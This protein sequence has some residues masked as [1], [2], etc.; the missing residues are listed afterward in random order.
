MRTTHCYLMVKHTLTHLYTYAFC[1]TRTVLGCFLLL[2]NILVRFLLC[3]SS[4]FIFV[5]YVVQNVQMSMHGHGNISMDIDMY[6]SLTI[7]TIYGSA[8]DELRDNKENEWEHYW[9]LFS[10]D[11][12]SSA[13]KWQE[14]RQ[15]V[16]VCISARETLENEM[17]NN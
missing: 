16:C 6:K 11:S 2:L 7:N 1:A 3:L 17:K 5:P 12:M 13:K 8:C 9:R 14:I 10:P 15:D 4:N